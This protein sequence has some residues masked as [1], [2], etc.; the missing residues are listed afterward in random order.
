VALGEKTEKFW[1]DYG[2]ILENK[3]LCLEGFEVIFRFCAS[4]C[5]IQTNLGLKHEVKL[6]SLVLE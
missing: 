4:Y 2:A 6:A 5:S 3:F 1:G